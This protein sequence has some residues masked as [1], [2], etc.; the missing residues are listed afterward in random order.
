MSVVVGCHMPGVAGCYM[1]VVHCVQVVNRFQGPLF[2]LMIGA[3]MFANAL[4]HQFY[5]SS[6]RLT[7]REI[8]T[9]NLD[10]KRRLLF[11]L[12]EAHVHGYI[13]ILPRLVLEL[14]LS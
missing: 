14:L 4:R 3:A 10:V 2:P 8:W 12:V 5:V 1:V 11:L 6:M 9:L 7:H 13:R